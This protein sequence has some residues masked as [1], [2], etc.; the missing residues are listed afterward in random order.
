MASPEKVKQ[1]GQRLLTLYM[2][3]MLTQMID[4][5]YRTGL[6]EASSQGAATRE[7]LSERAGLH[8]RYVREWL[9]AMTTA[10]I[11][12][13]DPGTGRYTLPAAHAALLTGDSARNLSPMGLAVNQLGRHVPALSE[14]F[15]TGD[16][17]PYS[18]YQPEFTQALDDVWH[19]I[20]DE[21]L[22]DGFLG[23]FPFLNEALENGIRVL[24]IGCGTGHAANVLA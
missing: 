5:G 17:I 3:S 16:G 23:T 13:Y 19:R 2:G 20:C 22:V 8:E 1:F 15:H 14:R 11:Y 21:Q 10:G 7:E 24:D 4:I 18:A 9:G 12:Q 6:C